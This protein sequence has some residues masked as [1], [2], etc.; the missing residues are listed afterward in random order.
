MSDAPT[1]KGRKAGNK[2]VEQR[3]DQLIKTLSD[4]FDG[5]DR[6]LLS[7]ESRVADQDVREH[8]AGIK[9]SLAE[10]TAGVLAL[11]QSVPRMVAQSPTALTLEEVERLVKQDHHTKFR[12]LTFVSDCNIRPGDK[13]DPTAKFQTT[14]AFLSRIRGGKLKVALAA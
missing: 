6:R 14:R 2:A 5:L 8:V 10:A 3:I 11:Q 4:R 1:N 12:A 7:L 13:F 9:A